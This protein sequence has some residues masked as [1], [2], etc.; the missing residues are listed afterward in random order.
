M[1]T[2]SADYKQ[3]NKKP[4]K[5]KI[6]LE[7]LSALMRGEEILTLKNELKSL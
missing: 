4:Q 7:T 3:Q 5:Q 2:L 1:C 6:H